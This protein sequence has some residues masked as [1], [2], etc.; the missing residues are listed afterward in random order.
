MKVFK[1]KEMLIWLLVSI[2]LPIGM[3]L[4]FVSLMKLVV[5]TDVNFFGSVKMLW[6]GGAYIFLSLF[7][8]ISLL[9]HFFDTHKLGNS[10][11]SFS[12]VYIFIT[13]VVLFITCFLYLSLLPILQ[14]DIAV[15]FPDNLLVSILVTIIGVSVAIAFKYYILREKI[16]AKKG[17]SHNGI[18]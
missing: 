17:I 15:S 10:F 12:F 18:A 1:S 13:I 9:P 2:I 8:L 11:S 5:K 14:N 16:E 6:E 7:V 3:P 4:G